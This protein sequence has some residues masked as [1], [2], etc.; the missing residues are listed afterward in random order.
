MRRSAREVSTNGNP[1]TLTYVGPNRNA[2]PYLDASFSER[3]GPYGLPKIQWPNDYALW[4]RYQSN[5]A[6]FTENLNTQYRSI[7]SGS[8]YAEELISAAFLRG[9]TQFFQRRLKLTGGVRGEQTNIKAEGPLTDTS[10]NVRRDASGRPIL[11]ANGRPQPITND[12]LETSKLTFISRGALAEKEYLRLFPSINASYNVR[13]NLIAR[14]AYY[15]SVGRP[16]YNQY[17]GGLTLPDTDM[18]PSNANRITL[19]NV[20]VKAWSAQS[21]KVRLEYYFEGVGQV[22]VGAFR[23]D[24]ENFFG[25]TVSRVTP[26]ILG[27]YGLDPAVYG[28]YDVSTQYTIT[29]PVRIEGMDFSYKQALTFLPPWA[30][31]LQVVFNGAATHAQGDGLDSFT[32]RLH[33]PLTG[34][35]GFSL[36]R[37]RYNLHVNWNWRSRQRRDLITGA[38]VGPDT[39]DWNPQRCTLDVSAEFRLRK[40]VSIYASLRNLRDVTDDTE[41]Y[42]PLTPAMNKLRTRTDY[43]ALW[44]FG[45]RNSF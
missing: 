21:T 43:G 11:A 36:T 44:Q 2:A 29:S 18:L 45:I 23:R 16:N 8:K 37:S 5:P 10:R 35:W 24:F 42:G 13:A 39:Y 34:N 12:A 4:R 33:V 19:T 38:S 14:A 41:T 17:T 28:H 31:G 27:T 30:R 15:Y 7:I 22:S 26:D 32:D 20:G 3:D 40:N 25:T 6:E 1:L 9:D